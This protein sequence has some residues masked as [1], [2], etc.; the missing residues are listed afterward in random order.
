MH[1]TFILFSILICL[2][3]IAFVTYG[4]TEAMDVYP[5]GTILDRGS[6]GYN[7]SS[8]YL[9]D[10]GRRRA[11]NGVSN[12][13][14]NHH[15][16]RAMYVGAVGMIGLFALFAV[17]VAWP[18]RKTTAIFI[19]L[20]AIGSA[21]AYLGIAWFPLDVNYRLHTI[22]VRVGFISFWWLS[23]VLGAL[24]LRTPRYPN[25]LGYL[26]FVFAAV[27]LVQIG[28]MLFGPRAWSSVSA[29]RLQVMAQKVVVF[30]QLGVMAVQLVG[31]G[32]FVVRL[33]NRSEP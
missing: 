20:L 16:D 1:K 18:R 13:G 5:G 7:W 12:A 10:L 22:F 19:V 28:I 32:R 23:L 2:S 24:I 17:L 6:V 33:P 4:V 15:F 14:S 25:F 31:L 21:L 11:W 27:F 30:L 8:N 9:S 26:M 3:S 29:L